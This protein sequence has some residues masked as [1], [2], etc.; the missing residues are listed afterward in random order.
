MWGHP[1]LTL[2]T[3]P[4][5]RGAG[6]FG[7]RSQCAATRPPQLLCPL[8][9]YTPPRGFTAQHPIH[10]PAWSSTGSERWSHCCHRPGQEALSC[11]SMLRCLPPTHLP[12]L[13]LGCGGCVFQGSLLFRGWCLWGFSILREEL[14]SCWI[15]GILQLCP[16]SAGPRLLCSAN[17]VCISGVWLMFSWNSHMCVS[18]SVAHVVG[19]VMWLS[20]PWVHVLGQAR[21]CNQVHILR[22]ESCVCEE[23][24]LV[25]RS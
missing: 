22:A 18:W 24:T 15:L 5:G 3:P 16:L 12:Q 17:H 4:P 6:A 13:F 10:V 23:G 2:L 25:L 9:C 14:G 11:T 19:A 21:V 7:Q 1:A 20:G 8:S